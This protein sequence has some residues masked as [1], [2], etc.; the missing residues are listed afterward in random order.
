MIVKRDS[1]LSKIII[2]S[3]MD[4]CPSTKYTGLI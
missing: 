1:R 4:F 2:I 3:I